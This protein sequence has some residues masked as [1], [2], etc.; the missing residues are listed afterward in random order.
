MEVKQEP[1]SEGEQEM[2]QTPDLSLECLLCTKSFNSVTGLKVFNL[3][4]YFGHTK[5]IPPMTCIE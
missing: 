3:Y 1:T 4:I 2:E 5:L